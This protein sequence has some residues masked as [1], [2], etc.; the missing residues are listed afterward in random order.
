MAAVDTTPAITTP[1]SARTPHRAGCGRQTIRQPGQ[2]QLVLWLRLTGLLSVVKCV[3]M[4]AARRLL[5]TLLAGGHAKDDR[6]R[7]VGTREEMNQFPSQIES[8]SEPSIPEVSCSSAASPRPA[9]NRVDPRV[10]VNTLSP[11]LLCHACRLYDHAA[12]HALLCPAGRCV[13]HSPREHAPAR[14]PAGKHEPA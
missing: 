10:S 3:S 13:G 12:R 2:Q 14:W 4:D 1:V 6:S 11:A 7:C 8:R 9:L 5:H